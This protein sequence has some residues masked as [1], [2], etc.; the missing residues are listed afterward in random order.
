[1]KCN[2]LFSQPQP[3]VLCLPTCRFMLL[4]DRT[5]AAELSPRSAGMLQVLMT[6]GYATAAALLLKEV[7]PGALMASVHVPANV[8]ARA[9]QCTRS[10][11]LQ[12]AQTKECT[13][14]SCSSTTQRAADGASLLAT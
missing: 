2:I 1:M 13:M 5:L 8:A 6:A 3:V 12:R 10:S 14:L 11:C 9:T 7:P 4:A